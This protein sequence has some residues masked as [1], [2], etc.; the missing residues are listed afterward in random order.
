M[1]P[2]DKC[3]SVGMAGSP[4]ISECGRTGEKKRLFLGYRASCCCTYL[5][6]SS[7]APQSDEVITSVPRG[8]CH[9]NNNNKKI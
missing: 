9:L 4:N 3:K 5:G 7:E 8:T 2:S 1:L 6:K